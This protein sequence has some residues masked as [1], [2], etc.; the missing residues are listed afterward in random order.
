MNWMHPEF[1]YKDPDGDEFLMGRGSLGTNNTAGSIYAWSFL[2]CMKR[3]H[4][5]SS[6]ETKRQF[7]D[8]AREIGLINRA[9][10]L[11]VK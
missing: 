7:G 11:G 3:Q 1:F 2:N 6:Q 10:I 9:R 4:N 5:L 8:R